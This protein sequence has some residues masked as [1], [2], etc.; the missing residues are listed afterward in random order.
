MLGLKEWIVHPEVLAVKK[1][2]HNIVRGYNDTTMTMIK[3]M[4]RTYRERDNDGKN[5][6]LAQTFYGKWLPDMTNGIN[7]MFIYCDE[8]VP[9]I[10]GNTKSKLLARVNYLLLPY[11]KLL[12]FS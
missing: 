6:A 10:V 2:L 3:Y 11:Y 5:G 12:L 7:Q 4:L 8:V 9:S 1:T